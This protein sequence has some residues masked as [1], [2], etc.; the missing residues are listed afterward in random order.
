MSEYEDILQKIRPFGPHQVRTFV[1]VS[2]FETPLAW[3][4]LGPIFTAK[5][6]LFS[7]SDKN[8]TL[9]LDTNATDSCEHKNVCESYVFQSDFTS[10][11]SEW[12]LVCGRGA[13]A[14]LI[15]SLQ[16]AGVL[17][18][19]VITGQLA[20]IFGRKKILFIEYALLIVLWFSTGFVTVWELY[21]ALRF[22]IGGL[23]GGCLVVNFV[24]PL[25][26]VTPQWRTFCGCVGFWAVGLMTLALWAFLVR[27]WRHLDLAMS[28]TG[29]VLL[30]LW[31]LID[32]SPRW[33]LSRG[34]LKEAQEIISKMA[35]FN[36]RP[37][38]DMK[39][40]QDFVQREKIRINE[41]KKYSYW[42]LFSSVNQ[43]KGTLICMFGWFVSSS[44]YYGHNFNSK[45]LVG[46]MY[47]NVFISG[48]V[49]IPA[50]IFV[51]FSNNHLGRRITVFL[52]MLLSGLACV[53]VLVIDIAGQGESMPGL[54]ISMAMFGKSCI[55]G[56]WA[57]VQILSAETF[58][59]VIRNIGIGACSMAARIG[60]IVAPQFGFL[61]KTLMHVP[62][63]IFGILAVTCSFLVL[64]LNE[65]KDAPLP[66]RIHSTLP[67]TPAE[68][69]L[70]NHGKNKA[71]NGSGDDFNL[72]EVDK[73]SFGQM[74]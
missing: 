61:G 72:T 65:T 64:L 41:E 17:F 5:T 53:A 2:L 1:L 57:A 66:D 47:L 46:N 39:C 24:L 73:I 58:P 19:A 43:T 26:F 36:K 13:V 54:T 15:T 63:T 25:E 42:H 4:M 50:L 49:E 62:F 3:A 16:M 38:P 74:A 34:H 18:G 32:E 11:V 31:W 35:K 23:I 68:V 60:G 12:Q 56:A 67:S 6:P 44:V 40:L 45:N 10:I 59:T 70:L 27:D 20:D 52:L 9:Y 33:L 29:V 28:S 48:L 71:E 21:A 69:E 14:D 8:Q 37:V 22:L 7:C 51:L 55:S 30:P